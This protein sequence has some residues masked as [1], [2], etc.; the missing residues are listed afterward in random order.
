M[1]VSLLLHMKSELHRSIN[2]K[3]IGNFRYRAHRIFQVLIAQ[4]FTRTKMLSFISLDRKFH[5]AFSGM[6][7]LSLRQKEIAEN[8]RSL[9]SSFCALVCA[10]AVVLQFQYSFSLQLFMLQS[11]TKYELN[12]F[13]REK[14]DFLFLRMRS[15]AQ[16]EIKFDIM[17]LIRI[18][19]SCNPVSFIKIDC[20]VFQKFYFR[21]PSS[22]CKL[23]IVGVISKAAVSSI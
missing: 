11:S 4:N 15:Y 3:V 19:R 1:G 9:Y 18:V 8:C 22:F 14:V 10:C 21:H 16:R 6:C 23:P 2:W 5:S 20:A 13:I 12:W 17:N 7:P